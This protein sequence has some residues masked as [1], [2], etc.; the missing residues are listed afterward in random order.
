MPNKITREEAQAT[1]EAGL[2]RWENYQFPSGNTD[3]SVVST[4]AMDTCWDICLLL[5]MGNSSRTLGYYAPAASTKGLKYGRSH[6]VIHNHQ[7]GRK[8]YDVSDTV[9]HELAHHIHRTCFKHDREAHGAKWRW[10][11]KIIG[12]NPRATQSP[13]EEL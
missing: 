2:M 4:E 1:L 11:C 10:I 7:Y 6:I 5:K 9:L 13:A 3:C 12:A 8:L